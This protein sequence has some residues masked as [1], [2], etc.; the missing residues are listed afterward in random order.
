MTAEYTEF[1]VF[2]TRIL[3]SASSAVV[4]KNPHISLD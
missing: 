2:L 3:Y 1:G 4:R